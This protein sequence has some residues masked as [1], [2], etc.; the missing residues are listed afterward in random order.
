MFYIKKIDDVI[1]ARI[2]GKSYKADCTIPIEDL[3]Y[4]HILHKDL[5]KKTHEGEMICNAYIAEELLDIF[6]NLYKAD[7]PIERVRLIDEY[8]SDD[9]KSMLANNS[10]CFNFRRISHTNIISKHGLGLAVDINPLYNPYIKEVDGKRILE[11]AVAEEYVDRSRS[12]PYKIEEN[13]LCCKLFTQHG[14]EW[15]GNCWDNRKDYQHFAI[16]DDIVA[17]LY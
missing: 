9:E 16:P 5:E 14:F 11:P 4:L 13:D 12:F 7:Y 1:F 3:R 17:K 2:N 8:E 10:S 6:Q 15:G